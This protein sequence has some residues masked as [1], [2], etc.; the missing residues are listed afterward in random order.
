PDGINFLAALSSTRTSAKSGRQ[1]LRQGESAD[2][3]LAAGVAGAGVGSGSSGSGTFRRAKKLCRRATSS[4]L[5]PG[6]AIASSAASALLPHQWQQSQV[7]QVQDSVP[8]S[9]RTSAAWPLGLNSGDTRLAVQF[10]K[11]EQLFRLGLAERTACL[12]ELRACSCL[13]ADDTED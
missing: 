13:E 1:H 5:S 3:S 12:A 4:A 7:R 8:G 2:L 9:P 11:V 10:L 6:S